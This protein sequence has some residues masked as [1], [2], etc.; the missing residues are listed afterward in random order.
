MK[1]TVK[2]LLIRIVLG[3]LFSGCKKVEQTADQSNILFILSYAHTFQTWGIYGGFLVDV[4]H[5]PNIS[6]L[7]EEGAVLDNCFCTNSICTPS[8]ATILIG[9]YSHQNGVYTLSGAM[10]P[11][12]MNI[13]KVFQK[14]GCQTALV[15]KWHLKKE[16]ADYDYYNVLPSQGR[17]WSPILKKKENW[18]NHY[19]GG[20]EHK[21]FSSDVIADLPIDW[22]KKRDTTKPFL[23]ICHFKATHEPFDYPE[24]FKDLLDGVGIPELKTLYDFGGK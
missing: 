18:K 17:H 16:P 22:I 10:E 21:G 3:S 20:V 2:F 6:K 24:R 19:G 9:Q 4:V 23:M 15:G 14:N 8:Q 13:V 7:A 1:I 11:D 5:T 12:S